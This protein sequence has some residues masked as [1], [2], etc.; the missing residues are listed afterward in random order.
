[1]FDKAAICKV[2]KKYEIL[3][4]KNKKNKIEKNLKFRYNNLMI[5]KGDG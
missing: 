4:I 5:N 1:M 2:S 3:Q